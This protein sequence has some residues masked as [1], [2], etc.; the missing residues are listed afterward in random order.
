MVFVTAASLVGAPVK[1]PNAARSP[2][3]VVLGVM[4]GGGVTPDLVARAPQY[5]ASLVGLVLVV[6]ASTAACFVFFRLVGRFDRT[7][8]FYSAVPGGLTEMILM[9]EADGGSSRDIA[10][11][12]A[13]RILFVILALPFLMQALSGIAIG[14]RPL[15]GT[16]LLS[17]AAPELALFALTCVVGAAASYFV[18][19]A[20][21]LF[22]IPLLLSAIVHGAGLSA[23]AAPTELVVAAQLVIGISLGARFAGSRVSEIG[24]SLLLALAACFI[25]LAIS[26]S[27]AWGVGA[28]VGLDVLALLLSYAPGGVAEMSLV[29]LA[30]HI[31]A[32]IVVIHH[33]VRLLLVTMLARPAYLL[34]TRLAPPRSP[35]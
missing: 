25:L 2:M 30:L 4:L 20:T 14:G 35:P 1:V 21:S 28:I 24:R 18:R 3:L 23:F 22:L 16:P 27:F 19:T 5:G 11:I 15:P 6:I 33:L 7:T 8:A 29:A 31:D 9:G 10:T 34:L 13:G 17:L 26:A 12:H 32:A